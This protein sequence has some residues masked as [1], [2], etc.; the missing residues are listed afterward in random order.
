MSGGQLSKAD[1]SS[2]AEIEFSTV[3]HPRS[4]A[5]PFNSD[6]NGPLQNRCH[7]FGQC[8]NVAC[9]NARHVNAR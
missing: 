7:G 9:V 4:A 8:L 3:A 5:S 1:L 6:L 2:F